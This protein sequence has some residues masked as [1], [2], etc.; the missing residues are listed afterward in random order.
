MLLPE[1]YYHNTNVV[2]IAKD[3]LGK[4]LATRFDGQ[5]TAGIIT[6]TEAYAGVVDKAAHSYG[7]RRTKRTETMFSQGGVSYVYLCYG[8]HHLFNI[9]TNHKDVPEAVLIR[10]IYPTKGLEVILKRRNALSFKKN[11]CVG[12]GKVSAALGINKIHDNIVLT[13]KKIWLEDSGIKIRKKD[14][15]IGPRIGV[16]YAGEDALLPYRF[17]IENAED[18]L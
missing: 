14:I 9:V 2:E 1:S 8:I 12:P 7:G 5:L 18:Y 13:G 3:L 17:W 16:D 11:L 15:H 6:E 10:A 4:T